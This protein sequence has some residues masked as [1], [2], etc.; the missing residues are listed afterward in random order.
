MCGKSKPLVSVVVPVYNARG[1]IVATVDNLERQTYN[2]LEIILV[3]DGSTDDSY[4]DC[5]SLAKKNSFVHAFH[6]T[7]G[8]IASA[9]NYG[10]RKASGTYIMFVDQDDQLDAQAISYCVPRMV[11]LGC[12][13]AFFKHRVEK[14][15]VVED[16][17]PFFPEGKKNRKEA[18]EALFSG[19]FYGNVWNMIV[20]RQLLTNHKIFFNEKYRVI[21]DLDFVYRSISCCK[22]ALFIPLSFYTWINR[23]DSESHRNYTGPAEDII[24]LTKQINL[25]EHDVSKALTEAFCM[26]RLIAY[27]KIMQL[28]DSE[29]QI[30]SKLDNE[31]GLYD[32]WHII[33]S[34]T[35]PIRLRI[36]IALYKI[37]I[38]MPLYKRFGKIW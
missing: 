30:I 10:L 16:P 21:D 18:K 32:V 2:N 37:G 14:S 36:K 12:E 25:S 22:E 5:R 8:G 33:W 35:V 17:Y 31:L 26:D 29:N 23:G 6:K 1:K 11:E 4:R 28:Y 20:S 15:G 34:S 9:R 7:N 38:L 27:L 3:D 24:T 19:R 13:I